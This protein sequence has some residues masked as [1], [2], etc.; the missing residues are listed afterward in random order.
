[1]LM[2]KYVVIHLERAAAYVIV[3]YFV[4]RAHRG[5]FSDTLLGYEFKSRLVTG[6]IAGASN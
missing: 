2:G 5:H 1:M 3:M 4:W 6:W